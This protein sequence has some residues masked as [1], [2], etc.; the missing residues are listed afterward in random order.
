MTFHQKSSA[1]LHWLRYYVVGIPTTS[2]ALAKPRARVCPSSAQGPWA[3][4]PRRRGLVEQS[5]EWSPF[6]RIRRDCSAENVHRIHRAKIAFLLTPLLV[7]HYVAH[8][9]VKSH[10]RCFRFTTMAAPTPINLADCLRGGLGGLCLSAKTS[11]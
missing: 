11:M 6:S 10:L 2:T 8:Q 9:V 4:G 3:P 7:L 1:P 5:Q